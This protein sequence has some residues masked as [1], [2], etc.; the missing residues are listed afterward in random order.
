MKIAFQICLLTYVGHSL[1]LNNGPSLHADVSSNKFYFRAH[2]DISPLFSNS[3]DYSG[4]SKQINFLLT[5][6]VDLINK[7]T[8]NK[9]KSSKSEDIEA[10]VVPGSGRQAKLPVS[11]SFSSLHKHLISLKDP[12]AALEYLALPVEEYSV[13]DS[14]L[15]SRSLLSPDSFI[16]SLPLGDL[17]SASMMGSGGVGGIKIAATLTTE[18]TVRPDPAKGRVIMESGPIYFTPTV[19]TKQTSISPLP[20]AALTEKS[21]F[22]A[23]DK[24]ETNTAHSSAESDVNDEPTSEFSEALPEWLLWGGR[25]TPSTSVKLKD[26]TILDHDGGLSEKE[27]NKKNSVEVIKSSV[28]ARFR[29]ELQW[30]SPDVMDYSER[31]GVYG[32]LSRA[33]GM[34]KSLFSSKD[35]TTSST[36]TA[37]ASLEA[38]KSVSTIDVEE[39][40]TASQIIGDQ[41]RDNSLRIESFSPNISSVSEVSVTA[42]NTQI[43][44]DPVDEVAKEEEKFLPVNAVVKVWLDVNL[45]VQKDLASA[46]SFPPVKLLLNQ[47]GALTTKAVLRTLAPVL[48]KLLVSDHESR[49][50]KITRGPASED[51]ES[52]TAPVYK[53]TKTIY[54]D[55]TSNIE[56]R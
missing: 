54:D 12:A 53:Q 3:Q 27:E 10:E 7:L 19:S 45:P 23:S 15:V 37:A 49:K 16:L 41:D 36:A 5:K 52:D 20:T 11:L 39:S 14:K 32:M 29:I 55:L 51:K 42:D 26:V 13:L 17:S 8:T 9:N 25:S 22:D 40:I 43:V 31:G 50:K 30:D 46:I 38:S 1:L 4:S 48:G 34:R 2:T 28:Q 6:A 56:I 35:T 21:D 47:A 33:N 18:V 44:T 24:L